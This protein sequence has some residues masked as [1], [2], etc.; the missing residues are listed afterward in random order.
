MQ[1]KDEIAKNCHILAHNMSHEAYV[2]SPWQ[3]YK[4]I[5][6]VNVNACGSGYLHGIL[7]AYTADHPEIAIDGTFANEICGRSNDEYRQK[8]CVHF[9]G[10]ILIINTYGNLEE[11]LPVCE[12]IKKEWQFDCYNGLFM[13]DHQKL[14]LAEH[15][16]LP[17]PPNETSYVEQLEK[18]CSR[19][20]GIMGAA[21]WTEMA[22]IYAHT[23]GYDPDIIFK[24]C[25]KAETKQFAVQCYYKGTIAMS[26]YHTFDKP[27]ALT[28]MCKY[29]ENDRHTYIGC[30]R[31]IT[32]SLMM[33]SPKFISRG[34]SFCSTIPS[35]YQEECYSSLMD[36][37][38]VV[39]KNPQERIDYCTVLPEK[40]RQSCSA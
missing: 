35:T 7:E 23:Y 20:S 32:S 11:A 12:T 18:Q 27:G 19:Y 15:G 4:L 6:N 21:C 24:G 2:R 40:Y 25:S 28:P 16:I 9:I 17:L 14:M 33:Y 30:V 36:M 5:D 22:E 13:E 1:D 37:L 39:V 3:F 34:E 31:V 8:M 10:H 29:Y 26:V 38:K